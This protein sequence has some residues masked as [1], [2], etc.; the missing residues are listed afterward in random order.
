MYLRV[1]FF[2]V[3]PR[4]VPVQVPAVHGQSSIAYGQSSGVFVFFWV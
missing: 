2:N 3:I 1:R 4:S